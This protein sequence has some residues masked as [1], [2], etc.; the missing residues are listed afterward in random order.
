[1]KRIRNVVLTVFVVLGVASSPLINS[2]VN[3]AGVAL[4][5]HAVIHWNAHPFPI[6]PCTLGNHETASGIAVQ[7]G[8]IT[9]STDEIAQFVSCPGAAIGF[10]AGSP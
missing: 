4:P 6:D 3:A 7:L 10:M 1:M 9:L 5:F 8:A 2:P